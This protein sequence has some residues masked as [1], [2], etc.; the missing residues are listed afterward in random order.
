MG[1]NGGM[2][3]ELK[4]AKQGIREWIGEFSDQRLAEVYAF[5][6]DGKMRYNDGCAC[7]MGVTL[8]QRLHVCMANSCCP[9]SDFG[10]CT[11]YGAAS[12]M[13]GASF[14]ETAYYA[15]GHGDYRGCKPK[16]YMNKH[17]RQRRLS[18]ILRAEMR[19]RDRTKATHLYQQKLNDT[20]A[21]MSHAML[22]S[23]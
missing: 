19:R 13:Y 21:R 16:P 18:P 4:W 15:L 11:H 6:A 9:E 3:E 1:D 7:L 20:E 14:A 22:A 8:A 17:L 12:H 2:T 23:A 5:N 10:L